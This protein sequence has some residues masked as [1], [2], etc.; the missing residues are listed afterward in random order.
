M[1][2]DTPS[3]PSSDGTPPASPDALAALQGF[4]DPVEVNRAYE[5]S[6]WNVE[7]YVKRLM[8][9]AEDEDTAP[10]VALAAAE[11][12]RLHAVSVLQINE[13]PGGS[14]SLLGGIV[15][16]KVL[17]AADVARLEDG[18]ARTR[19][20]LEDGNDSIA[21][22]AEGGQGPQEDSNDGDDDQTA[23]GEAAKQQEV[24]G[25]EA[26]GGTESGTGQVSTEDVIGHRPPAGTRRGLCGPQPDGGGGP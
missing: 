11:M 2:D 17:P 16:A 18:A 8:H 6:G 4:V 25:T 14:P 9:I 12:L 1:T 22:A 23:G 26:P 3:S 7:K 20:M 24:G 10:R 13:A 15:A 5:N 21:A 19:R